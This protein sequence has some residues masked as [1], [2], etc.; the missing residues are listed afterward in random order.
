MQSRASRIV[1]VVV[2]V[3]GCAAAAVFVRSVEHTLADRRAG[4]R[5]F[6]QLARE[7]LDA[8]TEVRVAQPAYLALGQGADFWTSKVDVSLPTLKGTLGVLLSS[9][10]SA[11]SR[12]ALNQAVA[13]AAELGNVDGR[14]RSYLRTGAPLMAADIVFTE[15]GEAAAATGQHV[16]RARLEEHQAFDRL[17]ADN[18]K[19]ELAAVGGASALVLL[20]ALILALVPVKRAVASDDASTSPTRIASNAP[21]P[22]TMASSDDDL[23]LREVDPPPVHVPDVAAPPAGPEPAN[24]VTASAIHSIARICTDIGRAGDPEE[25]KQLLARA[26]EVLDASGLVLW[27]GTATGAELRPALAHGYSPEMVSR[28]PMVP[29]SSN[30]ATATAYRSGTLQIVLSRPDSPAKGAV[31][32]P[33]LSADGC[34]GV[35]SAEIRDGAESSETVQSLAMIF[36]AQLAGVVALP[37]AATAAP[38][39]RAA[40]SA[41]V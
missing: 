7:A 17:E 13:G 25:L 40:G 27:L 6:D 9:A 19:P 11:A 15:G 21:Q 10:T 18:R 20:V 34:V 39:Q 5:D 3:C 32:A 37:S 31:V 8:L 30:N 29:R 36:A 26:A 12:A 1:L 33:V 4:L 28:I 35:L 24:H 41:A 23:L 2:C 22:A 16:E 14:I 38:E